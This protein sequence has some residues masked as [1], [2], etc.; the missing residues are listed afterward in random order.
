MASKHSQ[1][2]KYRVSF[3]PEMA[4]KAASVA[5]CSNG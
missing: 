2:L 5:G 4:G 1:M 3:G